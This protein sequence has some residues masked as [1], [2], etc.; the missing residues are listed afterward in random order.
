MLNIKAPSAR[1][2]VV[3]LS[4]GNQQKVVLGKW[5]NT[6]GEIYIFDEPSRGIDVGSKQ[7]IYKVMVDLLKE[8]KAILM[9]SSDM[10]EVISMSDRVIVFK[11][12]QIAGELA[13]E[14]ITEENI[15]TLSIG[16]RKE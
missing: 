7:E 11:Q 5:F 15:L 12:G 2:R 14:E 6:G 9:V 1:T 10:P 13:G 3:N 8:G 16:D 4:G